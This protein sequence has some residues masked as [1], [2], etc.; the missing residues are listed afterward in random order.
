M[1]AGA[2]S[3]NLIE[4]YV[5]R[6]RQPATRAGM[7]RL[8]LLAYFEDK[9]MAGVTLAIL[10]A[11]PAYIDVTVE[12]TI[13]RRYSDLAVQTAVDAAIRALLSYANVDFGQTLYLSDFYKAAEAVPGVVATYIPQLRRTAA[14][15]AFPAGEAAA[16]F[17][18]A[19]SMFQPVALATS[20]AADTPL[21]IDASGRVPI[22][23][24][25]IPVLR[26]LTI[27]KPGAS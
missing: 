9:R 24:F 25:E 8:N 6:R 15:Q 21:T 1:R 17:V 12:I 7:M 22:A 13:D 3:G 16:V 2:P 27:L 10:D 26:T 14:A 5:G 23:D 11:S 4:L 18:Q 20:V 19:A